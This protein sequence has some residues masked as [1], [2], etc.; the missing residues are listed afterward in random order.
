MNRVRWAMMNRSLLVCVLLGGL[1]ARAD[2]LWDWTEIALADA[3]SAKQLPFVQ[4]RT[5]AMMHVAMFEAINGSDGPYRSYLGSLP[6]A[7]KVAAASL[8]SGADE[9][10]R[11]ARAAIA[12]HEVLASVFPDQRAALD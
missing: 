8:P 1:P 7:P 3:A 9:N 12:A 5:M 4:S 2:V 11:T 6:A 10:A